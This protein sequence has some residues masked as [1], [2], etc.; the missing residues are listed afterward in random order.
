MLDDGDQVHEACLEHD[1]SVVKRGVFIFGDQ[2][3]ADEEF[4]L[5]YYEDDGTVYDP[6][7]IKEK[8]VAVMKI[9]L[10]DPFFRGSNTENRRMWK[11]DF[12][13]GK[14]TVMVGPPQKQACFVQII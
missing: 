1:M 5:E 13:D 4:T 10:E 8:W 11:H 14:S 12:P 7:E 9:D 2:C 3:D 6:G